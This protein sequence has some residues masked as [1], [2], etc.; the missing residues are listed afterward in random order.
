MN[1][2]GSFETGCKDPD[3]LA[4]EIR[5]DMRNYSFVDINEEIRIMRIRMKIFLVEVERREKLFDDTRN[6]PCFR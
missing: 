3:E 6:P 4:M 5:E 2:L 1:K